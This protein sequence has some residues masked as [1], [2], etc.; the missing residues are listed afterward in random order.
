MGRA[1]HVDLLQA[2]VASAAGIASIVLCLVFL[3]RL[4]ERR[5]DLPYNSVRSRL[6]AWAVFRAM[7]TTIGAAAGGLGW[8][9]STWAVDLGLLAFAA[10]WDVYDLKTR[11]IPRGR[12]PDR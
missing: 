12:H 10:L 7:M 8:P 6:V 4:L 2:A 11:R 3:P 1:I 5:G 9:A